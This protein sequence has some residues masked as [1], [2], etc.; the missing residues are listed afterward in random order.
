MSLAFDTGDAAPDR[1]TIAKSGRN[2]MLDMRCYPLFMYDR[3]AHV[4]AFSAL[5]AA[6]GCGSGGGRGTTGALCAA[7]S[8][9]MGGL[10]CDPVALVCDAPGG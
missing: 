9:C 7:D 2:D 5:L 8:D 4:L 1:A 3:A 10:I 6:T